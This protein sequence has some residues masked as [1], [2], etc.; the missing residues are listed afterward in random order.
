LTFSLGQRAL[1]QMLTDWLDNLRKEMGLEPIE[2]VLAREAERRERVAA[3]LE[4]LAG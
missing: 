4:N 3:A 2:D 1:E